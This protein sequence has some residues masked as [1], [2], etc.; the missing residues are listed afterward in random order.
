MKQTKELRFDTIGDWSEIKL[1]IVRQYAAAYSTIFSGRKQTR[2]YHVYVDAFAGAGINISKES[3]KFIPGSPLNALLVEPAFREFHFIDLD[4]RKVAAL[5]KIAGERPE[6]H[7]YQGDCN[8][9]LLKEVF[10]QVRFEDYRRGLCLLDPYGLHLNW[11]VIQTA[12]TMRSIDLFLNF[13]IMDMNRTA[14]WSAPNR[15]DASSIT[16]MNAFWG[17]DSW[18]NIAYESVPGLF[19]SSEAK[20]GNEAVAEAFRTRLRK[21]AKFNYVPRPLPMRNSKGSI[22]YYLFFASPKAVAQDIVDNIFKKYSQRVV[23]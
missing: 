5:R 21:V 10:P 16:R 19:G 12:G 8:K 1:D 2:F 14:L 7:I 20:V 22:V 15:V 13:P 17:D 9:I 11:E 6:V 4:G 18:R 23:S 3:G